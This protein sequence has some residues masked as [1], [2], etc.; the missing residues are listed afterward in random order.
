V[1]LTLRFLA[2][3]TALKFGVA[4]AWKFVAFHLAQVRRTTFLSPANWR[5]A[6]FPTFAPNG[7]R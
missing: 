7:Q 4:D 1:A 6:S 3:L 5:I 2:W